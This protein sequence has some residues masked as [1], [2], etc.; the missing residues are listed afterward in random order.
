MIGRFR[1]LL[2]VGIILLFV[3]FLGIPDVLRMGLTIVIGV[4]VIYLTFSMKRA[5]KK[6]KFELR[7]GAV[8]PPSQVDDTTPIIHG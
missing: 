3:P 4:F 8:T 7:Q 5:Y 1:V 2:W 6:M